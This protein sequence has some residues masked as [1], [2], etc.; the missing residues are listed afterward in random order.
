[1]VTVVDSEVGRP[2]AMA[3]VARI[4]SDQSLPV[5]EGQTDGEGRTTLNCEPGV[6]TSFLVTAPGRRPQ[7]FSFWGCIPPSHRIALLPS[8]GTMGGRLEDA[9]GK[10]IAGA[11]MRLVFTEYL[12]SIAADQEITFPI[13]VHTDAAG[14]FDLPAAPE[15][16]LERILVQEDR[17]WLQVT[18][19]P[20]DDESLRR[21]AF[22]GRP[23]GLPVPLPPAIAPASIP[24][25]TLHLRVTD[26]KTHQPIHQVRVSAGGASAPNQPLHTLA[27]SRLDL[28]GDNVTWIFYNDK[29]WAFFLR[30]EADGYA[31]TPT[32]IVKTSERRLRWN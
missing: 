19:S 18:H 26:A 29:A 24:A 17:R 3:T 30:V 12:E 9:T 7:T 20:E 11:P 1:V 27:R 2:I 6:L 21:G 28:R 31:T 8:G 23:S 5:A 22:V 16:E 10:P 15:G 32:R 13:E 4:Q 25:L 14:R